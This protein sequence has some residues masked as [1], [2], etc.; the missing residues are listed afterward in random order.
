MRDKVHYHHPVAAATV[1]TEETEENDATGHQRRLDAT[2]ARGRRSRC[3]RIEA[4]A[5]SNRSRNSTPDPAAVAATKRTIEGEKQQQQHSR[6][7]H[8]SRQPVRAGDRAKAAAVHPGPR[9]GEEGSA[10]CGRDGPLK[11]T[12]PR[13]IENIGSFS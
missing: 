8:G 9:A 10:G 2:A 12:V 6:Q 11:G 5:E 13:E 7:Q 4:V 3:D 1:R